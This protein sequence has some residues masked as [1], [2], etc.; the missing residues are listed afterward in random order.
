[1]KIDCFI[2]DDEAPA[3][4]ELKYILS[5]LSGVVIAGTAFC[6]EE[7]IRGIFLKK[8]DLVFLD[9]KMPGKDGFEVIKACRTMQKKPY[10]VFATAYDQHAV[11]AFEA[12]V[13]DYVLKPFVPIRIQES[14]ERVRNLIGN[15]K[16]EKLY[17]KIELLVDGF[18][19]QNMAINKISVEKNGRIFLIPYNEI[20]FFKAEDRGIFAHTCEKAYSVWGMTSLDEI[21]SKLE[22]H[23]FF[24]SHRGFLINLNSVQEI[25]P[26][27]NGRY[28]LTASDKNKSEI[29]VS[30]RRAKELRNRLAI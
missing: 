9:I 16:Q 28:I 30:R 24:R 20:I 25:I 19:S 6:A 15:K 18:T 22:S 4:D 21:E 8:P 12:S 26:W 13:V 1:M 2:T 17:S 23:G 10:F 7:A 27:F 29:P 14:V 11:K 3:V 5:G